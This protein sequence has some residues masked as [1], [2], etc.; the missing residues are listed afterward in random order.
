MDNSAHSVVEQPDMS[1]VFKLREAVR[2]AL[3]ALAKNAILIVPLALVLIAAPQAGLAVYMNRHP[4]PITV[5][6][7]APPPSIS[8]IEATS[9]SPAVTKSNSGWPFYAP[10]IAWLV[11]LTPLAALFDALVMILT[12][13]AADGE[14]RPL[15]DL[16]VQA[17]K[18]V[19][20][21]WLIGFYV[22]VG[23]A[24]GAFLLLIGAVFV[25]ALTAMAKPAQL[26][27]GLNA[28]GSLQR[29][30]QLAGHRLW[31]LVALSGLALSVQLLLFATPA[32][33]M[34]IAD[35]TSLSGIVLPL[36]S[37]VLSTLTAALSTGLYVELSHAESGVRLSEAHE[38]FT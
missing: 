23:L 33:L 37:A 31:T 2:L 15:S 8:D 5:T 6:T 13:D 28:I 7:P 32:V 30:I 17:L 38:V 22:T 14:P 18:R 9:R 11:V 29:S 3:A 26:M 10:L 35:T 36:A 12:L 1:G 20:V 4:V 27:E 34:G 25:A 16:F 21:F 19:W 24:V